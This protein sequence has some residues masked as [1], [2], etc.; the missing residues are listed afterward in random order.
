[1]CR[2]REGLL[3]AQVERSEA[4]SYLEI[5]LPGH[6]IVFVRFG[7]AIGRG[8]LLFGRRSGFD[9]V[10]RAGSLSLFHLDE[11]RRR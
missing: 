7:G 6:V 9:L 10:I 5:I 1:M 3:K 2:G 4:G 8:G 11:T